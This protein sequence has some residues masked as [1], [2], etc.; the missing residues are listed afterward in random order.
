[1]EHNVIVVNGIEYKA[2]ETVDCKGCALGK[3][4]LCDNT[5]KCCDYERSDR[6]NISF[7]RHYKLKHN[8]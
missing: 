3:A 1:M 5:V 2:V 4:S 7:K 6:T 8:G